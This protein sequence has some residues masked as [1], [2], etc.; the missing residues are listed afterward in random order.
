M[1][2]ISGW[3]MRLDPALVAERRAAGI[4]RGTTMAE[5]ARRLADAEPD[6]ITHWDGTGAHRVAGL[7]S[8]AEALAASL[9]ARGLRPGHVIS[10]QLPNWREAIVVDLAAA[11]LGL[12]VNPIVPI[13][14]DAEVG[15]ILSDCHARVAFVPEAFRGIDFAAMME[16][17]APGLKELNR[18]VFVR[19]ASPRPDDFD[20]LVEEG[21]GVTVPWPRVA[22]EAAK[23]VMYTSGTTGRPKGVLHTHESLRRALDASAR[24]WGLA[25]GSVFLMPSPVTHVTGFSFGIE[26]P[27]LCGTRTVLM[28]KWNADEALDLVDRHGA[29]ATVGATPF[30]QELAEA[31][32]RQGRIT[33]SLKVFA[34]G[35]AA[36]PPEV[37]RRATAAFGAC[38]VCRVYGSTEAPM[39]TLGFVGADEADL[40]AETDGRVVDY[41]VKVAD[42]AG[43]PLAR[44]AEG[45]I[46]ARGPALFLGYADAGQTAEAFDA[47]GFFR[48]GDIGYL[49]EDDAIVITGRKKDLII[50]GGENLS[51]KEIEDALHRHSAVREAAA[52]S[53]PHGRLGETVCAYVIPVEG[54]APSL[55]ELAAFLDAQGLAKQKFPERVELVEDFPRTAS[56]KIKKD[57]LRRMIAKKIAAERG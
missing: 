37:V 54:A 52:V 45:E 4:W 2:D 49:T 56:G 53:M 9:W 6:R 41:E 22:P 27:F 24:H 20:A 42:E 31:A 25:P 10:M 55:T 28:E 35:G 47:D 40:A 51:A 39:I 57:I 32:R 29:N 8:N 30:L 15:L 13:Y 48:T 7:L 38:R 23:L 16:R 3:T 21:R 11:L 26:M 1:K 14:R 17:L 5:E 43:R 34:C 46:M 12:V 36:V 50:R 19:P 44:G 18:I 33:P